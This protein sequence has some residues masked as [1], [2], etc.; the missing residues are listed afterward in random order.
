MNNS[1]H[2]PKH[3]TSHP[4]GIECIEITEHMGFNLGNAIKYIWRADLKGNALEDLQKAH[5]Y[6]ERELALRAGRPAK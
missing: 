2:H 1:V 6:I 4:S 3:Y 5:W